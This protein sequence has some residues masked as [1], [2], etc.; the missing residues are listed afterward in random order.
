MV[1]DIDEAIRKDGLRRR[2]SP[3]T[4]KTY[5]T[6]VK[7]FLNKTQKTIDKISKK[8]VRL[9]LEGLSE[10][11]YAGNTLNVYHMAIKFLL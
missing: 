5:Q 1:I 2:C 11:G 3:K 9:F 7:Q 4:I 10:K 6:C 8:D